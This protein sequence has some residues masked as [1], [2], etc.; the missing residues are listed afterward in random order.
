MSAGM[1]TFKLFQMISHILW[2]TMGMGHYTQYVMHIPA[3]KGD[4]VHLVSHMGYTR[5][6]PVSGWG[7]SGKGGQFCHMQINCA[8]TLSLHHS[9]TFMS[10]SILVIMDYIFKQISFFFSLDNLYQNGK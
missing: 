10:Q 8:F 1:G 7:L 9:Q 6:G 2:Y 5:I 4:R 3:L